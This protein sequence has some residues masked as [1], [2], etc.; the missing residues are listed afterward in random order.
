MEATGHTLGSHDVSGNMSALNPMNQPSTRQCMKFKVCGIRGNK[1][2]FVRQQDLAKYDD[3]L[4]AL[5]VLLNGTV[6]VV[7]NKQ[8]ECHEYQVVW[9]SDGSLPV[10]FDIEHFRTKFDKGDK[11]AMKDIR[12][13]RIAYDKEYP[14][15]NS[16][17]PLRH[18]Q[19][20]QAIHRTT[21]TFTS[22]KENTGNSQKSVHHVLT[23]TRMLPSITAT[24]GSVTLNVSTSNPNG[25]SDDNAA[26]NGISKTFNSN[27]TIISH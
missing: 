15:T 12:S 19:N 14:E 10:S 27:Q 1:I 25:T 26:N 11:K 24:Q 8:R 6:T 3:K 7:P 21:G 4:I 20:V 5:N 17:G 2:L 18:C 23:A 13:A 22:T 9:A 16:K